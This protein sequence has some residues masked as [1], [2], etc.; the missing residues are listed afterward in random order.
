MKAWS[1]LSFE[2]FNQLTKNGTL[3][4]DNHCLT[5]REGDEY[6]E[7]AYNFMVKAMEQRGLKRIDGAISP[8]WMWTMIN[9]ESGANTTSL[10]YENESEI[11]I[12]TGVLVELE[13]PENVIIQSDFELWSAVLLGIN[14]NN[15]EDEELNATQKSWDVIFNLDMHVD[16]FG[17]NKNIDRCI[18]AVCWMLKKEYVISSVEIE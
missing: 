3:I 2:A 11:P 9:G 5:M 13:I 15:P 18:Q 1:L 16:N 6:I 4:C 14:F 8:I 10:Y 12:E 17:G 7:R